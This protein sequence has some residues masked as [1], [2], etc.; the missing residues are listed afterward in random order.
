[1]VSIGELPAT[2]GFEEKK[3]DHITQHVKLLAIDVLLAL[4]AKDLDLALQAGAF[5]LLIGAITDPAVQ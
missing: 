2:V 1:M 3:K 4:T 5:S